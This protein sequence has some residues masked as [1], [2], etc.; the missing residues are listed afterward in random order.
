MSCEKSSG[1]P[2]HYRLKPRYLHFFSYLRSEAIKAQIMI[3]KTTGEEM[4]TIT[5]Q[6]LEDYKASYYFNA[7]DRGLLLVLFKV[8]D[9]SQSPSLS[10]Y[11][12]NM[13]INGFYDV[14]TAISY[15][16]A[17]EDQLKVI[18]HYKFCSSRTK[19]RMRH[20]EL[21]IELPQTKVMVILILQATKKKRKSSTKTVLIDQVIFITHLG[22]G[23]LIIN[24]LA[25]HFNPHILDF[26][27]TYLCGNRISIF[28]D[29]YSRCL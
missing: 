19:C 16:H 6:I 5:Y 23:I 29:C 26:A 3:K 21:Y 27:C 4:Q 22:S 13:F 11:C 24:T 9:D 15:D 14:A 20:T 2:D 1:L 10:V 8:I 18:I 28:G 25:G 17:G 7:S 12:R